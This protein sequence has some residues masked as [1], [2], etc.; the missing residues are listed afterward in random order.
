MSWHYKKTII[1]ERKYYANSDLVNEA[2][3]SGEVD[4]THTQTHT[5]THTYTH[6]HTHIGRYV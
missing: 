1:I 5:H 3:D 6:A 2:V 4:T